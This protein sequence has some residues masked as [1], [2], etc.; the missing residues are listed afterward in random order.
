MNTLNISISKKKSYKI[1]PF[2]ELD[3][4]KSFLAKK[5]YS[6]YQTS[7]QKQGYAT[8]DVNFKNEK[9]G[10]EAFIY[11]ACHAHYK[12]VYNIQY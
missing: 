11:R 5:G 6:E 4:A 3:K 2:Y 9:T 8:G 12:I 10:L 1:F 7:L